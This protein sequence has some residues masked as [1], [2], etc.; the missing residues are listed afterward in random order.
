MMASANPPPSSA[1]G[2]PKP[3]EGN[4]GNLFLQ[5][6]E[7]R[8]TLPSETDWVCVDF[9][10]SV[11][12][13]GTGA[14]ADLGKLPTGYYEIQPSADIDPGAGNLS[15]WP[16]ALGV[17][18]PL[19]APTPMDSP[20]AVDGALSGFY[21]D[22]EDTR[23]LEIGANQAALAGV[24][25]IRDR[26]SW[27][28]MHLG[29][30]QFAGRTEY[31]VAARIQAEAG[32][33][34]LQVPSP[35]GTPW[36]ERDGSSR[37][38]FDLRVAYE[39]FSRMAERWDDEVG[40]WE[41]WN[42]PEWVAFGGHTGA[43]TAAFQK[44][45]YWA[46]RKG[47]P[48]ALVSLIALT[49]EYFEHLENLVENEPWPYFETFNFHQYFSLTENPDH[50]RILRAAAAGRPMWITES[51]IELRWEGPPEIGELTWEDQL[52]QARHVPKVFAVNLH[53]GVEAIFYFLLPHY[54]EGAIQFGITRPN[55]TPRPAYLALAAAGRLLA[56]AEPRGA[57]EAPD[58]PFI[59]A[60]LA[61]AE[62]DGEE[63]AV[64]VVWSDGPE[65]KWSIPAP[66]H[67]LAAYDLLGRPL[68]VEHGTITVGPGACY[69]V[70]EPDAAQAIDLVPPPEPG[71]FLAG[72][73]CPVVLQPRPH[74]EQ[75]T[76]GVSHYLFEPHST[77]SFPVHLYNFADRPIEA[78]LHLES[79]EL[80]QLSL[81]TDTVTIPP[82]GRVPIELS[83]ETGP[84]PAHLGASLVRITADCG[85]AGEA[86]LAL[87]FAH[88]G[89]ALKPVDSIPLEAGR[90][91][92]AWTAINDSGET[93]IATVGERG[94]RVRAHFDQVRNEEGLGRP[95][96]TIQVELPVVDD[97]RAH[98]RIQGIAFTVTPQEGEARYDVQFYEKSGASYW[99]YGFVAEQS[100][101]EQPYRCVV[102]F[103][104]LEDTT[105]PKRD[106]DGGFDPEKVVRVR[107]SATTTAR[108]VVFELS[109]LAWVRYADEPTP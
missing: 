76:Q 82:M 46:I 106:A 32:L 48:D 39:F 107:I 58:Q 93:A 74:P 88:V 95:R 42:E 52:K 8:I 69:L 92:E 87:R 29:P 91:A 102:L 79:A 15:R 73:P 5:G 86:L 30:D 109:D 37:Y 10:R 33:R 19:Q 23:E 22:P 6:E 97:E 44:A 104:K 12:K 2:I 21:G 54:P 28:R 71:P 81:S 55:Y 103:E 80:F 90:E 67:F 47:N 26:V 38:P 96:N 25:W 98:P 27:R 85:E 83:V 57:L 16:V 99:G 41:P 77:V 89:D 65:A 4:P 17:I 59:R 45:A 3:L 9:D 18:A 94:I 66:D 34:I 11:V 50:F 75:V 36:M 43:E 1:R 105:W 53:Q 108:T 101:F 20:V 70:Y 49:G 40:A 13:K 63:R 78:K 35:R 61:A 31:D 14:V 84:G 68:P 62:P 7:V 56:G 72:E 60:F 51:G 64:C 100:R 24:N